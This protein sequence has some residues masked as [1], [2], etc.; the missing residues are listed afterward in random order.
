MSDGW[1]VVAPSAKGVALVTAPAFLPDCV[2]RRGNA[3]WRRRL[4][5]R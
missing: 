5:G 3:V 4:P 2:R 1:I